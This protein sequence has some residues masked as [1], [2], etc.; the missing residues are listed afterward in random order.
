MP[1][2]YALKEHKINMCITNLLT[3]KP[4]VCSFKTFK[5]GIFLGKLHNCLI[6]NSFPSSKRISEQFVCKQ[7]WVALTRGFTQTTVIKWVPLFHT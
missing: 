6:K 3:V 1:T 2:L 5:C 7:K 4:K